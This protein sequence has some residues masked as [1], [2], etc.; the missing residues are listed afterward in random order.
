MKKLLDIS[1]EAVEVITIKAIK[2]KT[3]FKL[4]AQ[5]ILEDYAKS[6]TKKK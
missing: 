5:K 1:E 3:V 6:L 4:K 2:E